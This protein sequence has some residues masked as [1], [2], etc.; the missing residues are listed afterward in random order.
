MT[1]DR[2]A[3]LAGLSAGLVAG[4]AVAA[5]ADLRV[6]SLDWAQTSTL[7][8]LGHPPVGAAEPALYR[9]WVGEPAL[10]DDVRD[11]G[12]RTQPNMEWVAALKPDLV[13]MSLGSEATRRGL[14][15]IAPV[16]QA[17]PFTPERRPL[18]NTAALTLELARKLGRET[19]GRALAARAEAQFAAARTALGSSEGRAV[20]LAT[21]LDAR[22]L[23][24]HGAGSLFG[25]VLPRIGLRDAWDRPT[26][27]WG[28]S[29]VGVEALA[30]YPDADLAILEPLPADARAAFERPGLWSN[31]AALRRGRTAILPA[32][33]VFGD[34]VAATRFAGLV[35]GAWG[36]SSRSADVGTR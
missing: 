29:R 20:L 27:V 25:D 34:L 32:G 12:L 4:P 19:Q 17:T 21:F 8:A 28:T 9:R 16:W 24:V 3:L 10:P 11:V 5:P 30:D 7:L 18:A 14:E 15:R 26:S 2:R 36:E 22:H 13:G 1:L 35:A 23:L 6:V 33:W 31:L